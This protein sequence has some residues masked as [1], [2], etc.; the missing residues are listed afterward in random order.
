MCGRFSLKTDLAELMEAFPGFVFP[1]ELPPRYNIAPSQLVAVVANN[2]QNKVEFLRWGLIP[3]WAKEPS[4]GNRMINARAETLAEK[5]AFRAA[6]RRRRCLVLADG[7]YEWRAEPGRKGKTPLYIRLASGR[8]F[9]F[10][11]LWEHWQSGEESVLSCTII[12]TRPNALLEPIHDRMPLILKPGDYAHWLA[13]AEPAN[14][15]DLLQPYPASEMVAYPVSKLVNDP[16]NDL[17][18]C[19]APLG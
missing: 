19:V 8:P 1:A 13:E 5:P 6:Y 4:I 7:F 11:G 10:G 15:S 3:A 2:G 14:L 12:T 16:K 17:P 9:A 18:D